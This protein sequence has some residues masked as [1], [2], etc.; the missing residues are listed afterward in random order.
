MNLGGFEIGFYYLGGGHSVD[1][2]VVW[3]NSEKVLYGGCMVKEVGEYSMGNIEDAAPL[4]Q[5]LKSIDAVFERFNDAKIVIPG[6][7]K[8]GGLELLNHTKEIIKKNIN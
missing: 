8:Y 1:N 6:H 2:I 4:E 7:G 5:W 3:H